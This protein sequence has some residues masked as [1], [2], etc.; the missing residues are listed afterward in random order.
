VRG[1][2]LPA[3]ATTALFHSALGVRAGLLDAAERLRALGHHVRVVDQYDGRVFDDYDTALEHI[4]RVG[5][6]ALLETALRA[7]ADLPDRL[8]TIGFS[9]G[10]GMAEYVAGSRPGV[11]GVVM[12]GGAL[13]PAVIGVDWPAGAVGQV[14]VTA[15]DPWREPEGEDAVCAAAQRVG[16]QVEVFAYPGAGH[17]FADPSKAD[18]YQPAEA[19]LMWERVLGFLARLDAADAHGA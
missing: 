17:L 11:R 8:V 1:G 3:M 4:E 16:G 15:D 6:P 13:D 9:N 5:F 2:S 12:L 14:H 18:E 19:E 10:A 7:T